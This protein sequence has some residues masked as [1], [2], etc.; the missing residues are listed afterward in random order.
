MQAGLQGVVDARG[1]IGSTRAGTGDIEYMGTRLRGAPAQAVAPIG[2]TTLVVV[3]NTPT[4]HSL[5][6]S[7]LLEV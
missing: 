5:V 4:V 1:G 6:D 3:E 7:H 2:D